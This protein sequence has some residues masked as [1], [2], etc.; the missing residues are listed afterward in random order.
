M[1]PT[2]APLRPVQGEHSDPDLPSRA[3]E[4]R[5]RQGA[6]YARTAPRKLIV[7]LTGVSMTGVHLRA[8]GERRFSLA[9]LESLARSTDPQ[10]NALHPVAEAL[11]VVHAARLTLDVPDLTDSVLARSLEEQRTDGIED[12][13]QMELHG[14]LEL[15]RQKG[16]RGLSYM[17][18]QRVRQAVVRHRDSALRHAGN[19]IALLAD[20]EA[21]VSRIE[22]AH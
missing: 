6:S 14:A 1:V 21:L 15:L 18:R 10:V 8:Q 16:L 4:L 5:R 2:V 13:S 22:T 12:V 20:L 3:A 19:L 7:A 17:E 11:T 9:E